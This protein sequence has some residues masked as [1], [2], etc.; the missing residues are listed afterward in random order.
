MKLRNTVTTLVILLGAATATG[1]GGS[2][3]QEGAPA[4]ASTNTPLV[5][6]TAGT[7]TTNPNGNTGAAPVL[8]GPGSTP[9]LAP[10]APPTAPSP[11]LTTPSPT[12][13][14][15]NGLSTLINS[16][17]AVIKGS[18]GAGGGSV[19]SS[20]SSA[21]TPM[22][23]ASSN[24]DDLRQN[25]LA[26]INQYRASIG[27]PALTL[28]TSASSCLDGQAASDGAAGFAHGAFGK[29]GESAQDECPGWN[30]SP[31][32]SQP[33]CLKMMWD[34]GPGGGH[35]ENMANAAYKEVACGFAPVGNGYWMTQDFFR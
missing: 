12:T 3:Q 28:R 15:G 25:C 14:Q 9:G 16:I 18:T 2:K 27:R 13:T 10:G 5:A 29:C 24:L 11:V 30:G 19:P 22:N 6:N 35:Y 7:D 26:V 34:E 33:G 8:S 4:P 1:C 23:A 20:G 17:A 21:V 31:A 32:S